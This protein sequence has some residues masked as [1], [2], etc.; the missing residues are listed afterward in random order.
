MQF[1]D[2]ALLLLA[3]TRHLATQLLDSNQAFAQLTLPL[4][5][6]SHIQALVAQ[7]RFAGQVTLQGVDILQQ[8]ALFGAQI[9]ACGVDAI[10]NREPIKVLDFTGHLSAAAIEFFQFRCRNL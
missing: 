3:Q 9:F 2:E 5:A 6:L 1:V 8:T 10:V 4:L 7:F